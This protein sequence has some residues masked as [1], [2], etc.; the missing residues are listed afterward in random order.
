MGGFARVIGWTEHPSEKTRILLK[1]GQTLLC[2]EDPVCTAEGI[3]RMAYVRDARQPVTVARV[4]GI[5][6][7]EEQFEI[8]PLHLETVVPI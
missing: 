1:H 7:G 8:V 6:N 3:N 2:E 4:I 5:L